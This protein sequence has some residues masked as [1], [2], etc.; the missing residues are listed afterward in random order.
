[1]GLNKFDVQ[2]K[3]DSLI[4]S[5][6]IYSV[7]DIELYKN[8]GGITR[9]STELYNVLEELIGRDNFV[10]A[11]FV[12]D[13]GIDVLVLQDHKQNDYVFTGLT[14]GYGGEGPRGTVKVLTDCGFSTEYLEHVLYEGAENL[15]FIK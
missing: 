15:V 6:G 2:S 11:Y 4:E 7:R 9:Y 13:E 1:M 10:R 8:C 5:F 12:N 14:C 3:L